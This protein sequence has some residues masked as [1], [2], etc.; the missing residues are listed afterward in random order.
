MIRLILMGVQQGILEHW[1]IFR[2]VTSRVIDR[3][4]R[5]EILAVQFEP[6]IPL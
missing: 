6:I 3:I 2:D 4:S 5:E 1:G